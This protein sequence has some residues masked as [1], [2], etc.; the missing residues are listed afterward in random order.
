MREGTL[1]YWPY[2]LRSLSIHIITSIFMFLDHI[3]MIDSAWT[4]KSKIT[5]DFH[6]DV[7]ANLASKWERKLFMQSLILYQEKALDSSNT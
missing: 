6:W 5:I 1:E 2:N 4:G 3:P 7:E